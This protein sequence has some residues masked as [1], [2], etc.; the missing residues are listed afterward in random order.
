MHRTS[1][2]FRQ[3]APISCSGT[4]SPHILFWLSK[5]RCHGVVWEVYLCQVAYHLGHVA[6]D[7]SHAK[8]HFHQWDWWKIQSQSDLSK[9]LVIEQRPLCCQRVPPLLCCLGWGNATQRS[10]DGKTLPLKLRSDWKRS[11]PDL[12]SFESIWAFLLIAVGGRSGLYGLPAI[13]WNVMW[14]TR[15]WCYFGYEMLVILS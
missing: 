7:W 12:T 8:S 14:Q 13:F 15:R 10:S 1:T 6:G 2:H 3:L 9:K 4:K 11:E 5:R